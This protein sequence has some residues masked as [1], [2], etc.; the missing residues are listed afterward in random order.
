MLGVPPEQRR[1][2]LTARASY[3][4]MN[5]VRVSFLLCCFRLANQPGVA[6]ADLIKDLGT[7]LKPYGIRLIVYLPS[8]G[9]GRDLPAMANLGLG[10]STSRVPGHQ[11]AAGTRIPPSNI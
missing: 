10:N 6:I 3:Q 7:A 2:R 9:P 5:Q 8:K 4:R 11:T 1:A